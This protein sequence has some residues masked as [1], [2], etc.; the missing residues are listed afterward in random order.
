MKDPEKDP[1]AVAH[2]LRLKAAM[3]AKGF[4]RTTIALGAGVKARTVT[5]WT[6]GTTMPAP[7]ERAALRRMLGEYDS[8]G[9]PVEVALRASELVE[10]RQG[11]VLT[12]YQRHLY[13]QGREVAG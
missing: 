1:D 10:W 2:G 13:E 3:A 5:N 6:S 12:E 7:T 4:D 9:D 11:A 8:Q